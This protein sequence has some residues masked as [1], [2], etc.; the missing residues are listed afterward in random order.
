MREVDMDIDWRL[1]QLFLGEDG[2]AEVEI[3]AEN[4]K[5]VR[6][7]CQTFQNSARC[8]HARHVRKH[9]DENDGHYSIQIPLEIPDEEAA[10][11]MSTAEGF[12]QFIL[13]YGKI[14]VID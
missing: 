2:I 11:A 9:M 13:K 5:R 10:E 6:C 8:K 14:E 7:T 3:D 12:R 1:V 4:S